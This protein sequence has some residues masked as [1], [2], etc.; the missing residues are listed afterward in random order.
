[1]IIVHFVLY[2]N[3][4]YVCSEFVYYILFTAEQILELCQRR[5]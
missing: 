1:M 2:I 5:K 3:N 4:N